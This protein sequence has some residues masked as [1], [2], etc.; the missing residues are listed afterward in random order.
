MTT[1]PTPPTV[2]ISAD[3]LDELVESLERAV[4]M[5]DVAAGYAR[6]PAGTMG[7]VTSRTCSEAIRKARLALR[8]YHAPR[9]KGQ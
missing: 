7:P 3:L 1:P 5:L 6:P 4:D 8:R 9:R 2:Q